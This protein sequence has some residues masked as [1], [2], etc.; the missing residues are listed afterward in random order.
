MKADSKVIKLILSSEL[1]RQ[2]KT[3]C[4]LEGTNMTEKIIQFIEGEI[5]R[6]GMNI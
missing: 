4:S 1:R 2:F 3:L 6:S 5:E